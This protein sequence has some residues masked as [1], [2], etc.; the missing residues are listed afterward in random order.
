MKVLLPLPSLSSFHTV[1]CS[2]CNSLPCSGSCEFNIKLYYQS[3][4]IFEKFHKFQYVGVIFNNSSKGGRSL[5]DK[6]KDRDVCDMILL[7]NKEAAWDKKLNSYVLNFRGRANQ[8]IRVG[9]QL[10]GFH[11]W[12]DDVWVY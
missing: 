6:Y 12:H 11:E 2:G 10:K 9:Y 5:M 4:D 3:F 1:M 8:V 7:H